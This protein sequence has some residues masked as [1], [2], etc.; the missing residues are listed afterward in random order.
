MSGKGSLRNASATI[1]SA[2]P[3]LAANPRLALAALSALALA[4][5]AVYLVAF[6]LPMWLPRYHAVP[7]LDTPKILGVTSGTLGGF[8]LAVSVLFGLYLAAYRASFALRSGRAAAAVVAL[9]ALPALPLIFMYPGGA[10]D[11]YAYIAEADI[12]LRFGG[13]PFTTPAAS[14][15]GH[16]LLPFLDFPHET[17]HYGPLWLIIGV[18]LRLLAGGDLL[19]GLLVFKAG[20]AAFLLGTAWLV[21]LA[22]RRTDP[23][24]AVPATLLVAWNPLLL[25][26]LAGNGHNDVAMMLFALLAFYLYRRRSHALA[27][28]ALLAAVLVKYV[29]IVLLPLFLAAMLRRAGPVRSWLPT[30]AIYLAVGSAAA[31]VLVAAV[32][33][34]GTVGVLLNQSRWFTSSLSA[35]AHL[36]LS[37]AMSSQS[38]A[39][40]V[41]RTAQLLFGILY[42]VELRRVWLRP[43]SLVRESFTTMLLLMLVAI[44]WFQPWYAT[45]AIPLG[46]VAATRT[47]HAAAMALSFGAF[48]IHAV[49]GFAW[50]LGWNR[51]SAI[52]INVAATAATWLPT[53]AAAVV[54]AWS[55]RRGQVAAAEPGGVHPGGGGCRG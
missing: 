26:E 33:I 22:L 35:I 2:P 6:T 45:W 8:V 20:A 19:A 9:A 16:P 55:G 13:N 24:R 34:S 31:L 21:Y 37:G 7:H 52:A 29:A 32:G 27:V 54:A 1:S 50:R 15:P 18:A 46:A 40:L 41:S 14:L 42:L 25:F 28:T 10:G 36:W 47:S 51:G 43:E 44:S 53:G 5:A 12:V 11:V 23:D 48:M 30:A 3:G 39:H 38:A 49:M 17:T 4:S